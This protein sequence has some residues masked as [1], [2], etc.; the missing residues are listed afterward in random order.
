M[1]ESINNENN[2]KRYIDDFFD[3]LELYDDHRK[4]HNYK[5]LLKAGMQ[6]SYIH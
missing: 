1:S 6:V 5:S 2:F 4:K 3:N